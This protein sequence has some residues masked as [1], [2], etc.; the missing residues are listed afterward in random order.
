MG[1][2]FEDFKFRPLQG[3][4]RLKHMGG[5][6]ATSSNCEC[7]KTLKPIFIL[8]TL[9]LCCLVVAW[10]T[11]SP[12]LYLARYDTTLSIPGQISHDGLFTGHQGS[13]YIKTTANV[14]KT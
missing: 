1:Q 7:F 8:T 5:A 13:R 4:G 3:F 11:L 9:A 10:F 2:W 14:L 6:L 12:P